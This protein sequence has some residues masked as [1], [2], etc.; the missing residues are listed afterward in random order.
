MVKN[1]VKIHK[2]NTN[3]KNKCMEQFKRARVI[4]LLTEDKHSQLEIDD[5]SVNKLSYESKQYFHKH[6]QHLY[7]ISDDEIKDGDY[8]INLDNNIINNNISIAN[9][10]NNAPSC[11]KIIATTDTSLKVITG[12]VGSSLGISL[13][14]PSRQFIEKYIEI[15]NKSD[16]GSN[17]FNI[18]DVLVEYEEIHDY[19]NQF[20]IKTIDKLKVNPKDNTITIKK[21]KDS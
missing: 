11:K 16:I 18:T 13:P 8:W 6:P 4:L 3:L 15:Y 20:A 21:I 2:I 14:Q 7:I 9:F 17:N 12:I 1:S 19:T 10:A 5:L